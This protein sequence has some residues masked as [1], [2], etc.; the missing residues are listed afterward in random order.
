MLDPAGEEMRQRIRAKWR[1]HWRNV[2]SCKHCGEPI[3]FL[4]ERRYKKKK[5]KKIP[6]S[7]GRG[8]GKAAPWHKWFGGESGQLKHKRHACHAQQLTEPNTT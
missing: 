2:T 1:K 6:V 7:V 4:V 3:V 8:D 5:L